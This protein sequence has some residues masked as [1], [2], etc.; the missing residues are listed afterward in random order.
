MKLGI[1]K[2]IPFGE[3]V[4]GFFDEAARYSLDPREVSRL[5]VLALRKRLSRRLKSYRQ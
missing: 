2:A 4:V 3:L 5:A 1:R